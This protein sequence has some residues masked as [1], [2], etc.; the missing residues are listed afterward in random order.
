M[1][2][3]LRFPH[4]GELLKETLDELGVTQYRLA[5]SVGLP[6]SAVT[7]IVRGRHAVTAET[8]LR[9]A[10]F[11]NASPQYWLNLQQ[12]YDL[13]RAR[14]AHGREIERLVAPLSAA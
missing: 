11:F 6:H 13:R 5:K 3:T 14:A 4:P 7:A 2:T 10:R 1:K 8:A 12:E 9:L